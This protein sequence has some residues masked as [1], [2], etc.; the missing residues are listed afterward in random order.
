MFSMMRMT[1]VVQRY[2]VFQ[3]ETNLE[4]Q[5]Y[6]GR[7]TASIYGASFAANLA[8]ALALTPAFGLAGA[9][10]ATAL[11]TAGRAVLL[12]RAANTR[13]GLDMFVFAKPDRD[14][15]RGSSADWELVAKHPE[16]SA[17]LQGT[18]RFTTATSTTPSSP[19]VRAS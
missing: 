7:L 19:T 4:D 14:A 11:A 15:I 18:P 2:G 12:R 17:R 3:R 16:L 8:L 1:G 13:L 6:D 5:L 9:A 10:A